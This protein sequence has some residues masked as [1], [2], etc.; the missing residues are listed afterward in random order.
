MSLLDTAWAEAE[1]QAIVN[2]VLTHYPSP[3]LALALA[4]RLQK[5]RL[6]GVYVGIGLATRVFVENYDPM[7]EIA[8]AAVDLERMMDGRHDA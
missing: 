7:P 8:A 3:R 5:V 2:E 4:M 6:A 1:A